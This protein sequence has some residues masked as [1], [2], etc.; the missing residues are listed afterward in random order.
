MFR[1]KVSLSTKSNTSLELEFHFEH[2][3]ERILT[4]AILKIGKQNSNEVQKWLLHTS[5]LGY[6]N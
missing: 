4:N 5:V 2:K 3:F 1:N 6:L